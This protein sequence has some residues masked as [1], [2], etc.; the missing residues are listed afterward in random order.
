MTDI[1]KKSIGKF[2]FINICF[3]SS[4]DKNGRKKKEKRDGMEFH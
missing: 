4:S 3:A 2:I 1:S